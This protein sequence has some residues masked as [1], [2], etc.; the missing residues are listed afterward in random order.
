MDA[1]IVIDGRG[2]IEAFNPAAER[3]FD[4]PRRSRRSERVVADAVA[5]AR[6]AAT[7][8]NGISVKAARIIGIGREVTGRRRDGTISTTPLGRRDDGCR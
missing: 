1:I 5:V 8:W 7:I 3:L 4:T 6:R 2:R